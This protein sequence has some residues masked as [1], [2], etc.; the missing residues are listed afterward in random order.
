[1]TFINPGVICEITRPKLS[2]IGEHAGVFLP[3]G[4]VVHHGQ[5]GPRIDTLEAFSQGRPIKVVRTTDRSKQW[6]I[7]QRIQSS[8][9]R[10]PA[11]R[12]FD[13]NCEHF[14]SEILGEKKE[15]RQ[16]NSLAI[17]GII[18]AGLAAFR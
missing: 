15:S 9:S 1:M 7:F 14:V 3:N 18:F 5:G 12:L 4:Q 2:G 17:V 10:P 6:E 11:Y 8:L 16:I 13:N